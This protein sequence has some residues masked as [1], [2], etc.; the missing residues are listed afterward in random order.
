M[1]SFKNFYINQQLNKTQ[2]KLVKVNQRLAMFNKIW[3][4]FNY[5][6]ENFN[7][8]W[9]DLNKWD[10]FS[11]FI[12]IEKRKREMNMHEPNQHWFGK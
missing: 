11:K 6:W 8:N 10:K 9:Q 7:Y 2:Q 3:Y 1:E 4:K 12:V 5:S